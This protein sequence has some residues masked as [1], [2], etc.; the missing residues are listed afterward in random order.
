MLKSKLGDIKHYLVG[1]LKNR[2][3]Y[4]QYLQDTVF[5]CGAPEY[6]NLGDQAIFCAEYAMLKQLLPDRK[7]VIIPELQM[8]DHLLCIRRFT[9]R[10]GNLCAFLGGGNFGELYKFQETN[11]LRYVKALKKAHLIV[12]PQ[13][14]DY[15]ENSEALL[16]AKKIYESHPSLHLFVREKKSENKR[17]AFF[18]KC[19]GALVPDIVLSYR[20]KI[21]KCQR[22]GVI[23]CTR[24]DKERNQVTGNYLQELEKCAI[25]VF[26]STRHIDTYS[27]TFRKP[28]TQQKEQLQSFW[29][30][31]SETELIIT[32]RL[33]G[34]IFALITGTPCIALDNSTG[35]VGSL[36]QTWLQ[37]SHV[38]FV[39]D[40]RSLEKAKEYIQAKNY[41]SVDSDFRATLDAG[42][43][44]LE[45]VILS[46][47]EEKRK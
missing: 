39:N 7:I 30:T 20:P 21:Q 13:S 43:A 45:N 19:R 29:Q 38:V 18:P 3:M 17:I 22:E 5:I 10:Y 42:F 33:H 26:N 35:K 14:I 36:Y 37:D 1:Y 44:P 41:S 4:A 9:N 25:S 31:F 15:Q 40:E 27:E 34:M 28:Y 23:F 47:K 16:R 12:F 11:R 46:F 8:R 24:S 6:G 2:K 32:D